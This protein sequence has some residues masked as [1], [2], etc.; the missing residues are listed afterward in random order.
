ML[1][2]AKT[3]LK[4]KLSEIQV[5]HKVK[6]YYINSHSQMLHTQFYSVN[7]GYEDTILLTTLYKN[8]VSQKKKRNLQTRL[9]TN[10]NIL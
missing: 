3:T 5:K 2:Q 4:N 9:I 1:S 8:F 6:H 10:K 7:F